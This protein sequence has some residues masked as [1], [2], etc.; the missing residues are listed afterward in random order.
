[1]RRSA[2]DDTTDLES[3]G[4]HTVV[5]QVGDKRSGKA[6]TRLPFSAFPLGEMGASWQNRKQSR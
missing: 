5:R 1:M 6:A 4:A 2:T 3:D